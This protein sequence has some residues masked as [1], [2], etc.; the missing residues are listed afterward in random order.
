MKP[1]RS[2]PGSL[3]TRLFQ[4]KLK[5]FEQ[6]A[7]RI[8]QRDCNKGSDSVYTYRPKIQLDSIISIGY[9]P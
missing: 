4:L 2:W 5:V 1:F 6:M 9:K 7:Y 3:D 8:R